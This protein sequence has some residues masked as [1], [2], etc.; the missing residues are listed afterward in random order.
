M[1]AKTCMLV[2]A[3]GSVGDVLKT[4]PPLD[5]EASATLARKLFPSEKL[6]PLK[7]GS[8]MFMR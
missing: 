3:D 2:Y 6:Q 1:G 7:D 5:R 4:N 8:L